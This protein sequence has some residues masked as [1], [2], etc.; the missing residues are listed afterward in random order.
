MKEAKNKINE[1]KDIMEKARMACEDAESELQ[2]LRSEIE[3]QYD[4][5]KT[6]LEENTTDVLFEEI[7]EILDAVAPSGPD[8]DS[9]STAS[10]AWEMKHRIKSMI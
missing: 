1:Y 7:Y 10:R 2:R 3:L 5:L 6:F 9:E 4:E 8:L